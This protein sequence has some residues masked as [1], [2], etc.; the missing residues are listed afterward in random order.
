MKALWINDI[1]LEFLGEADL[2]HFVEALC[3]QNADCILIAGDIA[4]APTIARYLLRVES[5]LEIPIYFVLGNHDFYHGSLAGVRSTIRELSKESHHL[6]WLNGHGI[7][8]LTPNTCLVGH[9]GWGDG[10]LGDFHNS[11]IQLNDFILIDEL[12]GLSRNDLFRQLARL[13][14]EAAEHL[15][16]LLPDALRSAQHLVVLTHVPP[17]LEASWYD[18]RYCDPEWLPFFA[19]KAVGDVLLEAMRNHPGKR[20]TV[21]CGHTHGGGTSQILP[22]LT[23]HTGPVRYGHPTIQRVFSWE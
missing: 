5:A 20:M 7:V 1:H 10:R 22:N 9:D 16:A 19:C 13:G 2:E 17:F 21:L 14:D 12:A 8:H 3:S 23:T 4:Q 15:K 6:H 18:G 11:H